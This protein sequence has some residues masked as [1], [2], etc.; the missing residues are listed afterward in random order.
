M[1]TLFIL[2]C[3][4]LAGCGGGAT[5]PAPNIAP[6]AATRAMMSATLG[7]TLT[8]DGSASSD[9]NGDALTYQWTLT[10]P[11]G[12][13]AVLAHADGPEP[14]VVADVVG[15]YSA[16]VVVSDGRLSSTAAPRS[17]HVA[18]PDGVDKFLA[19]AQ[20]ADPYGC[21]GAANRLFLVDQGMVVHVARGFTCPD[22]SYFGT[23]YGLTPGVKLGSYADSVAG[24]LLFCQDAVTRFMALPCTNPAY[25]TLLE[26]IRAHDQ[27]ADLGL[28]ATHQV[29]RF[30]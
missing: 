25:K 11:A 27:D 28:G 4:A 18:L 15:T 12:S 3:V 9:A 30:F 16:T 29:L 5:A 10:T 8:F 2:L 26:T 22:G 14:S 23:L 19:I 7:A 1:K 20:A 6:V 24:P 17:V 21:F 13:H